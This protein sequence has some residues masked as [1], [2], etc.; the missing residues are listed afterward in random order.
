VVTPAAGADGPE[1]RA[2]LERLPS[3]V[4]TV[5]V[6]LPGS[7]AGRRE[8]AGLLRTAAAEAPAV[9]GVLS[10]L[11][12]DRT[13]LPG[14]PALPA[15]AAATAALVGAL[16]DTALRAPLWCAGDAVPAAVRVPLTA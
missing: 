2:A 7:G 12:L 13:P 10:L 15:G 9:A 1:A 6:D 16:H 11:A 3:G 8:L 14:A 4:R 5:R